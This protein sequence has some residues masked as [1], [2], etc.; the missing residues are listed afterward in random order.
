[1]ED[2]N[3]HPYALLPVSWCDEYKRRVLCMTKADISV[4]MRLPRTGYALGK[5]TQV[6]C[7]LA[8]DANRTFDPGPSSLVNT[9]RARPAAIPLI[10]SES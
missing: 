3:W 2:L 10:A 8:R 7:L 5:W 6:N 4:V 9:V 1:M